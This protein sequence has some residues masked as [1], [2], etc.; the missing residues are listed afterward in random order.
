M[1]TIPKFEI[2]VTIVSEVCN[3]AAVAAVTPIEFIICIAIRRSL[4]KIYTR[5][6][7]PNK[8]KLTATLSYFATKHTQHVC[9]YVR[10]LY[11]Q[12]HRRENF[13]ENLSLIHALCSCAM[14]QN[15]LRL[16]FSL[17]LSSSKFQLSIFSSENMRFSVLIHLKIKKKKCL[18]VSGKGK[19]TA[20]G[21][22]IELHYREHKI[23]QGN[24]KIFN[25][26]KTELDP[27]SFLFIL[28]IE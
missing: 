17:F 2:H 9:T 4:H 6:D 7:E 23:V 11:I 24:E 28:K 5:Y 3:I 1:Y 14:T 8:K 26:V 18:R 16:V 15:V 22:V 21:T 13:Y 20:Q 10:I 27:F 12:A 19:R 25:I